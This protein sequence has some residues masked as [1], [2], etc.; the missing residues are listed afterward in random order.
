MINSSL[1]HGEGGE[2][3]PIEQFDYDAVD[4]DLFDLDPK[5]LAGF[6]Q[7]EIDAAFKMHDALM[8]WMWQNGMRNENG[9]QIRA[10][11]LCWIF[12]PE[13]RPMTETDLARVFGKDKQSLNRWVVHFKKFFPFI[14]VPHFKNQ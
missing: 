12:I 1:G 13:L 11:I 5:E 7:K 6:T 4:R 2:L 8:R 3:V 9:L 10:S 14:K